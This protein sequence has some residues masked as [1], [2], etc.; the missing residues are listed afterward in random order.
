MS[1]TLCDV[2][3]PSEPMAKG[4][5][6]GIAFGKYFDAHKIVPSPA[7]DDDEID[8]LIQMKACIACIPSL[9]NHPVTRRTHPTPRVR[10]KR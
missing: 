5:T 10:A 4:T 6:G 3:N 9:D 7:Q 1:S 8:N 2:R